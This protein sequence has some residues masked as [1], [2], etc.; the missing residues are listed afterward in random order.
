MVCVKIPPIY[1]STFLDEFGSQNY[2]KGILAIGLSVYPLQT[3]GTT[4]LT[5]IS[6]YA[7]EYSA[8]FVAFEY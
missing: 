8:M 6:R 4:D 7:L 2:E 3:E 5:T 1:F